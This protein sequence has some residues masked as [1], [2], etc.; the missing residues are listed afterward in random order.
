MADES[1]IYAYAIAPAGEV[2]A[3]TEGLESVDGRASFR[4][5]P[6]G[7][8]TA[9]ASP[10][11]AAEFSQEEIDRHSTDLEW[12][13]RIGVRHQRVNEHLSQSADIIPLRAFTL[14]SSEE[15]LRNWLEEHNGELERIYGRT[16]GSLEWTL[17]FEFRGTDW[18]E[19]TPE[20][21]AI[22][23]ELESSPSGKAFLLRKKL[24]REAARVRDEAEDQFVKRMKHSISEDF[25]VPA[26]VETR[27][28]RGGA[29]P[30]I[31]VLL[32]RS[33]RGEF[34]EWSAGLS[35]DLESKGVGLLLTGPWPPYSF[36]G[37]FDG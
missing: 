33:R 8:W 10:V 26:V 12:L 37:G 25:D 7:D 17:R 27:S 3:P 28:T 21:A 20:L 31:S 14:F 15:A 18:M 19:E 16:R 24:E 6:Q 35:E 29:D 36:A 1:I 22:R 30:Q 9:V 34:E 13:G 2:L 5:V 32:P 23:T 11:P 4:E